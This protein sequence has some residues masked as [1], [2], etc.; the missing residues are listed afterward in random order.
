MR[1]KE[2]ISLVEYFYH[3]EARLEEAVRDCALRYI[4][5]EVDSVDLLEEIIAKE[6]LNAFREISSEVLRILDMLE[7]QGD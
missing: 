4:R 1:K 2:A 7:K 5:R 6:H 3:K